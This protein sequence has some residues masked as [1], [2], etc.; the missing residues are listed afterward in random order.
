M[1][2]Q[3]VGCAS[4]LPADRYTA[5]CQCCC[6]IENL[7][8]TELEYGETAPPIASI[9][10]AVNWKAVFRIAVTGVVSC[11]S[12]SKWCRP[13]EPNVRPNQLNIFMLGSSLMN[14]GNACS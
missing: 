1:Q 10:G 6:V 3:G 9:R 13:N 4:I 7:R 11:V 8:A 14:T 5:N 2:R 12:C